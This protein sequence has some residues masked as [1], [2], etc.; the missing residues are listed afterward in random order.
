MASNVVARVLRRRRAIRDSSATGCRRRRKAGSESSRVQ[1]AEAESATVLLIEIAFASTDRLHP[2]NLE[3]PVQKRTPPGLSKAPNFCDR[4]ASCTWSPPACSKGPEAA[5][6]WSRRRRCSH[7]S[8]SHAIKLPWLATGLRA[9]RTKTFSI[10]AL[11]NLALFEG[12]TRHPLTKATASP[13][14]SFC[15]PATCLPKVC[16]PLVQYSLCLFRHSIDVHVLLA[17][18]LLRV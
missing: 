10:P 2:S 1:A 13:H 8:H 11:K 18:M 6:C 7:L 17:F 14:S 15:S 4:H 9:T 3:L 5:H 12:L 16:M